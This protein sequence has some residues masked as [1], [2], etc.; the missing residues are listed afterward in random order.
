M[1]EILMIKNIYNLT[2]YIYIIIYIHEIEVA[3][4]KL[5]FL[6]PLF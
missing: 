2:F 5:I 3:F 4:R 6:K 1:K